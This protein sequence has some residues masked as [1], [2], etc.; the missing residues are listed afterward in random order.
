M[1]SARSGVRPDLE[2]FL[3]QRTVNRTPFLQYKYLAEH[4]STQ[5]AWYEPTQAVKFKA[6]FG[7]VDWSQV[8]S[9]VERLPYL[10]HQAWICLQLS[11][12]QSNLKEAPVGQ[13]SFCG[14]RE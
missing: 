6:F 1:G 14:H 12:L 10:A 13:A 7:K 9:N 5:R 4:A 8:D 3:S 11:M 2:K